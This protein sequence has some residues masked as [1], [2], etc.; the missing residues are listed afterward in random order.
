MNIKKLVETQEILWQSMRETGYCREYIMG[1]SHELRWIEANAEKFDASSYE[2]LCK[3]RL[4][5]TKPYKISHTTS[6]YGTF[7]RFEEDGEFPD[8]RRHQ[9]LVKKATYYKLSP[10]FKNIIDLYTE[11]AYDNIHSENTISKCKSKASCLFFHLQELGYKTLD[12]VLEKDVLSFFASEDGTNIRSR[13]YKRDIGMVLKSDLGKFNTPARAV[14]DMLPVIPKKHTNIQFLTEE[15]SNAIH[16]MLSDKDCPWLRRDKAIGLLLFFTGIRAGDI[17]DL[18]L[19]EIDW[20]ND[21]IIRR[22][23][24]TGNSLDLPLIAVV[25]NAIYDYISN[26]RP[27]V[28]DDHVFL[29]NSPPYAELG[30]DAIWQ[31]CEKIYSAAGVRRSPGER[32]GSHIFRHHLATHLAGKGFA[33]PVISNTLGHSEPTTLSYYLSAD[34]VHL[35]E[36]ALSIEQFPLG[37]EVFKR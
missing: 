18:R 4:Q 33:Q 26:D 24:K 19:N 2:E 16:N 17:A 28:K 12:N 37:K 7:K 9:P 32:R 3:I 6:M 35:R 25:G 29:W 34:M 22:Q 14:A 10:Y 23:Q 13:S 31:I 11:Y 5:S 27:N 21:L 1:Y 15:E 8:R 30:S 36:L 20:Q